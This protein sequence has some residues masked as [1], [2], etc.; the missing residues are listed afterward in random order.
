MTILALLPLVVPAVFGA[1]LQDQILPASQ[2]PTIPAD[3]EDVA[4][5]E[6]GE[7]RI[8]LMFYPQKAP[9][10]VANFKDL[11]NKKFYNGLRFHRVMTGFMIQSGDP[12]SRNL[13]M[14]GAWGTGGHT[15][16]LGRLV[17]V[18][19]EVS[20]LS[21]TRG[22]LSMARGPDFN[23]AGSQFFIMH[24][25][26]KALDRQ[27]SAFGRVVE[28]IEVVDKIVEV[29]EVPDPRSGAVAPETAVLIK[30]VRIEKWPLED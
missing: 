26:T 21:H 25:D 18:P 27:Y 2:L 13:A 7:G 11:A 8:V 22:V 29:S 28:G 4:V 5:M 9:I 3:G 12:N 20:D 15:D 16:E 24:K 1:P 6:T 23:S 10:H 17:H 19:I 30:S 14:S